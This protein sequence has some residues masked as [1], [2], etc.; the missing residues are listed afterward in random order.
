MLG[1]VSRVSFYAENRT[2]DVVWIALGAIVTPHKSRLSQRIQKRE[3]VGFRLPR[4]RVRRLDPS[5]PPERFQRIALH[6]KVRLD[7]A[8]SCR[9]ARMTKIVANDFHAV[10]GL[11][12]SDGATV[13]T[14]SSE[15]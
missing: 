10:T 2:V 7:V 13:P 4:S 6:L 11:Q 15:T 1:S 3:E 8:S 9:D 14:M 12:Q 5:M